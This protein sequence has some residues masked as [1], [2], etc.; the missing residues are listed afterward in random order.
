MN[1]SVLNGQILI[2]MPSLGD[3][4]F[5]RT[6]VLLGSHSPE[7][8]AFG[9]IVNRP[10]DLDLESVLDQLGINEAPITTPQVLAGGPVQ[11]EQG[12]VLV[13]GSPPEADH[14]DLAADLFTISGRTEILEALALGRLARS[15]YLCLGYA[16]WFPGQLEQE[17][18]D[19]SWLVAPA[20]TELLFEVPLEERWRWALASIGV[21]PGALVD[22]GS[23]PPS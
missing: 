6:V 8:G 7:E 23:G 20:T 14:T 10:S 17:I 16:G 15:F 9:L 2:A 21:D 19:N 22:L 18:E 1:E 12:F 3:P 4:N 5:W 13:S 11:T